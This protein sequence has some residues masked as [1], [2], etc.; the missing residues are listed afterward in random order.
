MPAYERRI[1]R[2]ELGEE[3]TRSGSVESNISPNKPGI[4]PKRDVHFRFKYSTSEGVYSTEVGSTSRPL[5]E[6]VRNE[7]QK[8][9]TVTVV[10]QRRLVTRR[11]PRGRGEFQKRE[12][13]ILRDFKRL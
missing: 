4:R 11:R 3:V 7:L 8:G 9:D 13:F 10:A 2:V 12:D 6:R 5:S 1:V